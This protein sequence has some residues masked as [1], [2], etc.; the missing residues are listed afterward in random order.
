[1]ATAAEA[2]ARFSKRLEAVRERP[3]ALGDGP[4]GSAL[5][6]GFLAGIEERVNGEPTN[7]ATWPPLFVHAARSTSG[8]LQALDA[9]MKAVTAQ[10]RPERRAGTDGW[11]LAQEGGEG[12]R[13]WRSGLFELA[14]KS[15]FLA[16]ATDVEFDAVLRNGRDVDVRA[17]V[18]G[19]PMCFDATVITESDED[20][21]VWTRFMAAKAADETAVLVRPGDH[22]SDDANGPSPYYDT[23]RV[24]LKLYDKLAKA[25]DPAKSQLSEDEPNVITLSVWTGHGIPYTSSP[26][27][28]WALDELFADQPNAGAV[29]EMTR[30][31]LADVSLRH[32][33]DKVAPQRAMELLQSPRRASAVGLFNETAYGKGRINYNASPAHQLSHPEMAAIEAI[34]RLPLPWG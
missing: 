6:E 9:A 17:T 3:A 13:R 26:G 28:R 11:L 1:M 33:L 27:I 34:T 29:K 23:I 19:R 24:C 20:Q 8:Q 25:F 14:V 7:W 2:G 32:F 5:S 30:P 31:G 10:T 4:L 16:A 18:A 21:A 12:V 22:D 15:R